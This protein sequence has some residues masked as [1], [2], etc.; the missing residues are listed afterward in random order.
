MS[1]CFR[2]MYMESC[3]KSVVKIHKNYKKKV[4]FSMKKTGTG[5]E[6]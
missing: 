4:V 5:L 6:S 3:E 1:F 2:N